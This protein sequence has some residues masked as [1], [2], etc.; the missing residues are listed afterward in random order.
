MSASA[1]LSW[2]SSSRASR[3]GAG[4]TSCTAPKSLGDSTRPRRRVERR[5]VKHTL[6][7]ILNSHGSSASGVTPR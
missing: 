7:A 5:R 1:S 2:I 6:C 3:G 4:T